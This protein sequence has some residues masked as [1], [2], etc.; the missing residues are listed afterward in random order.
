[1]GLFPDPLLNILLQSDHVL[2]W[3]HG[4]EGDETHSVDVLNVKL[5]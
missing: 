2:S 1:M 4:A 5:K 3:F